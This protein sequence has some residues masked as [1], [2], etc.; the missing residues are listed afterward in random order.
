MTCNSAPRRLDGHDMTKYHF[1]SP[2]SPS[3]FWVLLWGARRWIVVRLGFRIACIWVRYVP[4]GMDVSLMARPE[5][6]TDTT[7]QRHSPTARTCL[8]LRHTYPLALYSTLDVDF[9]AAAMPPTLD[10][11]PSEDHPSSGKSRG[12]SDIY[13]ER[14]ELDVDVDV[15]TSLP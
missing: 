3:E 4:N 14:G 8:S 12:S 15:S 7:P 10:Y 13:P 1:S 6:L 2:R 11:A 5:A 9:L